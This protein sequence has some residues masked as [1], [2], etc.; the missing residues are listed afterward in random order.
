MKAGD[1]AAVEA[2]QKVAEEERKK[3]EELAVKAK[4]EL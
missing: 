1:Q 4:K 3:A 2:A